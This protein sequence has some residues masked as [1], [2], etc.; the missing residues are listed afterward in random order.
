MIGLSLEH[1]LPYFDAI[2]G[3]GQQFGN[4]ASSMLRYVVARNHLATSRR[5]RRRFSHLSG[6]AR[7]SNVRGA[8]QPTTLHTMHAHIHH[9]SKSSRDSNGAL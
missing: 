4:G 3:K 2:S 9:R 6:C 1:L 5:R 8:I 7:D